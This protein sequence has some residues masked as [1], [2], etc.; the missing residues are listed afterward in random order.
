MQTVSPFLWFDGTAEDAARLYV[1]IFP[2][3]TVTNV[4]THPETG[5]VFGV[6]FELD[7][8]EFRALNAGPMFT[9]TEAISFF[10]RAETQTEIDYYWDALLADGGEESRCGWLKDRFGLSWQ[11]IPPVLGELISSSDTAAAGRAMQAML[12]MNKIIIADLQAAFD[13]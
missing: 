12:G 6:E 10:I 3:S 1:S 7:G 13:G 11:V 8:I 2:N 4:S 9:F 5:D